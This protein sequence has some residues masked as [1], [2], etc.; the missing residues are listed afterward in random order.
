[1]KYILLM[2]IGS[3]Y[4]KLTAVELESQKLLGTAASFTTIYTDV[5]NGV[6]SALEQL[7]SSIGD[8][9]NFDETFACSSAA[10]GL[11]IV[12]SGLVPSL[13]AEA[14]KRASLG[15]GAKVLKVFSFELTEEDI[16]ETESL[17]PDIFLLTGGTNGGNSECILKNATAISKSNISCPVIIAGNRTVAHKCAAILEKAGKEIYVTENVMPVFNELNIEPVQGLIRDIFLKRIIE[18]KGLTE[19]AHSLSTPIIPT[20]SAILNAVT[21]YADGCEQEKGIGELLAVDLG[22]ATTDVYSVAKGTPDSGNTI[23]RGLPE[24]YAKRTVEGDIGMRYS[25][26]GIFDAVSVDYISKLS[27]LS[28]QRAEEILE[29]ITTQT[30][31]IPDNEELAA[32]DYALASAAIDTAVTRHVGRIE[33]VYTPMGE[34]FLQTGKD[35]RSVTNVVTTGG[36]IIHS[37]NVASIVENCFYKAN[38]PTVLKPKQA[39]V[40]VDKRYIM[41]A[42]GLLSQKYPLTALNILKRELKISGH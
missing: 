4:T 8:D 29:L 22:G 31:I 7:K 23:F 26:K 18:A 16:L 14:A 28:P 21:L 41:S 10:G 32:F 38:D 27:A 19:L 2:D 17:Q 33:Q 36:A 5:Q 24:V 11:K 25:A 34:A 12:T 42:M 39:K 40:Y 30:D 1:M 37:D 13:T 35:L 6:N 3:T 15:A 20:P 9:I